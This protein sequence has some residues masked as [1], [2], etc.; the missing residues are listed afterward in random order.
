VYQALH[1][2][3]ENVWQNNGICTLS[4]KMTYFVSPE[5]L[6]CCNVTVRV[7]IKS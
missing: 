1:N 3:F 5:T 2:Y 4:R 6:L 7:R